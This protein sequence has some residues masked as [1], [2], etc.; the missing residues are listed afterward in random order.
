MIFLYPCWL[1]PRN[2]R[3]KIFWNTLSLSSRDHPSLISH[4]EH[5]A[6]YG[7]ALWASWR[8][9]M[10][11]SLPG[12]ERMIPKLSKIW[13]TWLHTWRLRTKSK[14]P[15]QT[16]RTRTRREISKSKKPVIRAN[17]NK[18]WKQQRKRNRKGTTLK[19]T[20]P[21][22]VVHWL[23]T[24]PVY[25]WKLCKSCQNCT[26]LGVWYGSPFFPPLFLP[27]RATI[28]KSWH[29]TNRSPSLPGFCRDL[30]STLSPP[31]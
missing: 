21:V 9:E 1:Q 18:D 3:A 13:M 7:S 26:I 6:Q 8:Y 23:A 12:D 14:A 5:L 2:F 24:V 16:S 27:V 29:E 28:G 4:K 15:K 31:W 25:H 22:D 10:E 19:T 17:I 11:K 30:R 20:Y